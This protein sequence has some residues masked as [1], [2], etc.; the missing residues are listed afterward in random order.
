MYLCVCSA[1]SERHVGE[2]ARGG[3]RRAGQVHRALG[4]A[5]RCAKCIPSIQATLDDHEGSPCQPANVMAVA[6]E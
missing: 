4:C 3:V 2:L 1:I 5:V 6:A